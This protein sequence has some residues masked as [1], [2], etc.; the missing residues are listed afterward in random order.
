MIAHGAVAANSECDPDHRSGQRAAHQPQL[1]TTEVEVAREQCGLGGADRGEHEGE[2]EGHEE[3][4]NLRLAVEIRDRA[5]EQDPGHGEEDAG[6]KA[7]PEGGR[8]VLF[9]QLVPLD[10]CRPERQVAEDQGQRREDDHHPGDPV[11][12]RREQ[13][14]QD[15]GHDDAKQLA[16]ELRPALPQQSTHDLAAHLVGEERGAHAARRAVTYARRSAASAWPGTIEARPWTSGA[17][18]M[19]GS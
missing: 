5:C 1:E 15:D 19:L 9:G 14:R 16:R 12:V 3:P 17:R 8:A 6:A 11:V 2:R 18:S 7:R 4:P 10:E 13:S